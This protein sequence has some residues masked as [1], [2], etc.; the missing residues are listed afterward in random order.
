MQRRGRA[1]VLGTRPTAAAV[2]AMTVIAL[3]SALA[4]TPSRA[5]APNTVSITVGGSPLSSITTSSPAL[6]PAFSQSI[7]DYVVRCQ[8]G[9]NIVSFTLTAA[10]GTI[11]V[12]GQSGPT[13]TVTLSL[14]ENQ[15]VILEA[16]DPSSPSGPPTHYWVRCLPH[17]FPLIT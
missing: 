1:F 6:A 12:N 4:A 14:R 7:H 8:S 17:D 15:P 11:Q 2:T 13:A 9:E 5:A 10:S 16:T 3:W